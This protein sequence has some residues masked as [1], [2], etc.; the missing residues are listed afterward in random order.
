MPIRE[1]LSLT[2]MLNQIGDWHILAF[3][4]A[5]SLDCLIKLSEETTEAMKAYKWLEGELSEELADCLICVLAAA[6]RSGIDLQQ[7]FNQ[8]YPEVVKKH[9]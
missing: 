1:E 4:W 9:G 6:A 3:P 2:Q 5:N 7:A 8:K